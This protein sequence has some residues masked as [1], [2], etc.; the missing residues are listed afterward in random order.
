M[1]QRISLRLSITFAALLLLGATSTVCRGQANED[2]LELEQK[3]LQ[4]AVQ[5]VAPSVVQLETFGGL[6]RVDGE[7]IGEGPTTGTIID[8]DGW[9]IS[10]LYSFRQQPASILV[11]L[12]DGNRVPAKIV[13]RDYSRELALLKVEADQPLTAAVAVQADQ[14]KTSLVGTWCV[15]LG[16]TY[17]K[18]TVSQSMG[19]VSAIGRAYGRAVQT[20]AKVSPVNYGGPLVDISGKTLGIL[21]PI[22]PGTFFD[23]DSSELYDSGIGFAIPLAD[24]LGRLDTLKSGQDVYPGKLGVVTSS[25]NELVG[26][27]EVVGAMPGSPAAKAGLREGDIL[28]EAQ[29]QSLQILANLKHAL[30]QTDAGQSFSL[31]VERAGK[32]LDLECELT[33]SV[34]TYRRRFLGIRLSKLKTQPLKIA[35]IA[36]N[37]PASR[38]DLEAGQV[39][40]AYNDESVDTVEKF[41]KLLALAELD[42]SVRLKVQNSDGSEAE[43]SVRAEEW[44]NELASS[45]PPAN[46]E[47]G[48][49]ECKT[50]DINVGD[51]ANKA[52]AVVPPATDNRLGLL[53]VFPEPGKLDR[54][55]T[56]EFWSEFAKDYGWIVAFIGSGNELRW[57]REELELAGRVLGRLNKN[58]EIDPRRT[59]I[60]GFGI[61]GRMALLAANMQPERVAGVLTMGTS[62]GGIRLR[63]S[64]YP[65]KSLDYL[66][67]GNEGNLEPAAK[68]LRE[69]GYAAIV[70]GAQ[71]NVAKDWSALPTLKI[72][73]WLEGL[74]RL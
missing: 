9:I 43:I 46:S 29:G 40:V 70:L 48:A 57:S 62:L 67:V 22:S 44:P 7:L 63:Q 58:Y 14:I 21:A 68:A 8:E 55:T 49:N 10:T 32:Q 74:G 73:T 35:L 24:I 64:N 23:G 11:A 12:P 71:E 18:S 34:P 20:D 30:S 27:I 28:L 2:L 52:F 33:Q 53:V 6:E 54:D 5:R 69:S 31:S 13:A 47:S 37:S 41:D 38:S 42:Q 25:Q 36:P 66:L 60:G 45:M 50:V 51:F 1:L 3:A 65:L 17:D 72:E 59:V 4:A 16:K 19:I 56:S 15:A 26:P 39:I 61:G